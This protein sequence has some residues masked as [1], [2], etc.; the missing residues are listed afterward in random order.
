M[1]SNGQCSPAGWQ[2][3]GPTNRS[4][5]R[6]PPLPGALSTASNQPTSHYSVQTLPFVT[7]LVDRE[8]LFNPP[9][10]RLPTG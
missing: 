2:D 3:V 4:R 6:P 8:A 1:T 5:G 10:E 9:P 7:A